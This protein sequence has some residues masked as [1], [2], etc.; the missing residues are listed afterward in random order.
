M[1]GSNLIKVGNIMRFVKLRISYIYN[2]NY[3]NLFGV[4]Y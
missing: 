2:Y 1:G 4:G 3:K